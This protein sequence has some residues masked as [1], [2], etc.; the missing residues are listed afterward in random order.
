MALEQGARFFYAHPDGKGYGEAIKADAGFGE[1]TAE[2][3]ELDLKDG[4]E[5]WFIE[6]DADSGWPIVNWTDGTGIDRITTI[7]PDI[8][9][10]NFIPA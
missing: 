3:S 7:S 6:Y 4:Q 2:M 9:D 1:M 8:F 5:V 10:T